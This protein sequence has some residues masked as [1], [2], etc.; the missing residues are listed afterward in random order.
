MILIYIVQLGL[1]SKLTNVT[2]YKIDKSALKTYKM[3]FA[4]FL[5]PNKQ[6]S[7]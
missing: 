3:I 1:T 6:D 2:I 5:I 7:D 4:R